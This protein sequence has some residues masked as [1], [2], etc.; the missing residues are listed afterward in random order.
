MDTVDQ[1]FN[2]KFEVNFDAISRDI[3]LSTIAGNQNH[4]YEVG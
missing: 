1:I 2:D 3:L 4:F